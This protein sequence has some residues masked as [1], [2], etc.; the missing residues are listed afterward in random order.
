MNLVEKLKGG[1]EMKITND[2]GEKTMLFGEDVKL[3][4]LTDCIETRSIVI[5]NGKEMTVN[6]FKKMKNVDPKQGQWGRK[7]LHEM[8][9]SI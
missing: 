7:A 3:Y 2:N 6:E 5:V 1:H 9:D 4:N 8:D